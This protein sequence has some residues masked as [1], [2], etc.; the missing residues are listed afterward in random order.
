MLGFRSLGA[1]EAG[2]NLLRDAIHQEA[3]SSNL[4]PSSD[5]RISFPALKK[6]V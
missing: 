2:N 3:I 1:R 4:A 6:K 5:K